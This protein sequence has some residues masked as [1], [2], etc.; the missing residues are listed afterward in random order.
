MF[1]RSAVR[2]VRELGARVE[3]EADCLVISA[4]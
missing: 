4:R 1:V 3:D 2:G